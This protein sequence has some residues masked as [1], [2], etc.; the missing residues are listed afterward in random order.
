MCLV[1]SVA[2]CLVMPSRVGVCM[3][4]TMMA[5]AFWNKKKHFCLGDL[6]AT[7]AISAE[8][9]LVIYR[10]VAMNRICLG[11]LHAAGGQLHLQL[12]RGLATLGVGQPLVLDHQLVEGGALA[13]GARSERL[14]LLEGG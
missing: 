13:L 2:V 11:E 3:V 1:G 14:S 7:E 6:H 8:A 12:G 4:E 10:T 5:K 9:C